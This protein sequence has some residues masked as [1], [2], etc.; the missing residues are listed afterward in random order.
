[1]GFW[2]I[3]ALALLLMCVGGTSLA[4]VTPDFA[5]NRGADGRRGHYVFV[6]DDSGSMQQSDPDRMA[7]FAAR[8]VLS[9]LNNDRD[10]ASVLTLNTGFGRSEP[11]QPMAAVFTTLDAAL[12]GG[13]VEYNGG[14]TPCRDALA[15]AFGLLRAAHASQPDAAQS[16]FILSDGACTDNFDSSVARGLLDG[17]TPAHREQ[18]RVFL[19]RF[20]SAAG[21][22]FQGLVEATRGSSQLVS[23]DSPLGMLR[24]FAQALADA[25]G[26]SV[27][28]AGPM[29]PLRLQSDAGVS[30]LRVLAVA[31]GAGGELELDT[32]GSAAVPSLERVRRGVHRAAG[33]REYRYLSVDVVP[34]DGDTMASVSGAGS[35]WSLIAVPEYR[36][37]LYIDVTR[38][39]CSVADA[40]SATDVEEP[41]AEVCYRAWVTR[42]ARED[43]RMD[44][45][46]RGRAQVALGELPPAA[47][48]WDPASREF[49]AASLLAAGNNV[50]RSEF[51]LGPQERPLLRLRSAA[52]SV[53]ALDRRPVVEPA[54]VDFGT[55]RPGDRATAQLQLS[56]EFLPFTGTLVVAD[57][58]AQL[59]A[60]VRMGANGRAPGEPQQFSSGQAVLVELQV[61][62]FCGTELLDRSLTLVARIEPQT[63]AMAGPSFEFEVHVV[64]QP[65]VGEQ[66]VEVQAGQD[67]PYAPSINLGSS[68]DVTVQVARPLASDFEPPGMPMAFAFAD[69]VTGAAIDGDGPLTLRVPGGTAAP[70]PMIISAT[71]CCRDGEW[72]GRLR[73]RVLDANG[74]AQPGEGYVPVVVRATGWDWWAWLWCWLPWIV[75]IVIMLTLIGTWNVFRGVKRCFWVFQNAEHFSAAFPNMSDWVPKHKTWNFLHYARDVKIAKRAWTLQ[76]FWRLAF[77]GRAEITLA[78]VR[79]T[80]LDLEPVSKMI[81]GFEFTLAVVPRLGVG[82]RTS[83]ASDKISHD[84]YLKIFPGESPRVVILDANPSTTKNGRATL[85]RYDVVT[86]LPKSIELVVPHRSNSKSFII[87]NIN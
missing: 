43:A 17:L 49:R 18:L 46:L 14:S 31:P 59:P 25:Q 44:V 2:R 57:P 81:K 48:V 79:I 85:W 36:L 73:Y 20:P 87:G 61:D 15:A 75:G 83:K 5:Q 60:C 42:G 41:N 30:R 55:V 82:E 16:L 28:E 66:Q 33:G 80:A 13:G 63:A 76:H 56:G 9:M 50:F 11:L 4:Q 64:S 22:E 21:A 51:E 45:G 35:S 53:Q 39:A 29:D 84:E 24:P 58:N 52:T 40:A 67:V 10:F 7:L 27:L 72:R 47:A 12:G 38:G 6:V 37:N 19:L 70:V 26:Y 71:T 74:N 1:M 34:G 68:S 3:M 32:S 86:N 69:P 78:G 65:D 77:T 23:T 54:S 8:S 62:A